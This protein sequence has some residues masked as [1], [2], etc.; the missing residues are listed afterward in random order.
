M[1]FMKFLLFQKVIKGSPI[2][3]EMLLML[4]ICIW[5]HKSRGIVYTPEQVIP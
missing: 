5:L 1:N 2:Q 3:T 4:G